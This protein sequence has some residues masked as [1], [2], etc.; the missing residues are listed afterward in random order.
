[1][2]IRSLVLALA[3]AL[4][5]PAAASA[6]IFN[7][8]GHTIVY[9]ASPGDVDQIAAIETP[10]TLRFTRFGGAPVGPGAGCLFVDGNTI[11]CAKTG[12]TGVL[13][14]LGDGDDVASISPTIHVPVLF[15][16]GPGRDGLFG[17]GGPD[18]FLGG[19][20]TTT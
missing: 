4:T 3:V 17:G 10:T 16:G 1:V 20:A 15:D 7:V 19:P 11:D 6:G 8:A 18:R 13:L 12:V 14:N 9:D 5:L 2:L